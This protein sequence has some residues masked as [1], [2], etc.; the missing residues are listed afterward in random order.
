MSKHPTKKRD[1]FSKPRRSMRLVHYDYSSSGAYAFTLGTQN[2]KP[3]FTMP[4][5]HAILIEEWQHLPKRFAGV[6]LDAFVIMP[7]HMH[8]ILLL[9][10]DAPGVKSVISVIGA[11]KSLTNLAWTR[12]LHE[13][14]KN[15]PRKIWQTRFYDHIIRDEADLQAQRTYIANNPIVAKSK[16]EWL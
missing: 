6:T 7:N 15:H 12:H 5:L 9:D 8:C 16:R 10:G 4:N 2:R 14:G 1:A 11:Y 13:I 3:F